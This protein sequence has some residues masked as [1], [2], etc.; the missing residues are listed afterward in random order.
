MRPSPTVKP[1]HDGPLEPIVIPTRVAKY[2]VVETAFDGG[3]NLVGNRKV[4]VGNGEG[5]HV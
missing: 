2:G 5:N 1:L 4:C 3:K